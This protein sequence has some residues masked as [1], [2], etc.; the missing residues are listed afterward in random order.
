ML[1]DSLTQGNNRKEWFPSPLSCSLRISLEDQDTYIYKKW[2]CGNG[3]VSTICQVNRSVVTSVC[4]TNVLAFWDAIIPVFFIS[5]K[6]H[7]CLG[8][9][10]ELRQFLLKPLFSFPSPTE[11]APFLPG[12]ESYLRSDLSRH[13]LILQLS[14]KDE[15]WS[16]LSSSVD[17][18]LLLG[19]LRLR[20]GDK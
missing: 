18:S 19:V 7:P 11:S 8:L 4:L 9:W 12:T 10:L 17:D 1:A 13:V 6:S 16:L 14:S 2:M 3:P 5:S 15:A 20:F